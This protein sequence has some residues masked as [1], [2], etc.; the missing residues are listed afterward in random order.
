MNSQDTARAID[1]SRTPGAGRALRV[2]LVGGARLPRAALR[3]LIDRSPGFEV[4]GDGESPAEVLAN[5][6][7]PTP[8]VVL[9]D[10][11]DRPDAAADAIRRIQ[12][13]SATARILIVASRCDSAMGQRIVLAG[14]AGVVLKDNSPDHLLQAIRKVH[15][16]ELWIDRATT[17][18]LISGL[19]SSRRQAAADPEQRKIESLTPREHEVI[20]L[21][22]AGLN[23]K[24]IAGKMK[25]SENTVRH[26]LTAIFDKLGA[27]DRLELLVY[28]YRHKI[29]QPQS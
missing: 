17:A 5:G 6:S 3:M 11:D 29:V 9:F 22:A 10:V 13:A 14:A 28:A 12:Q 24:A 2:L 7:E 8:D 15:E 1:T 4:V 27:T 16:G 26:H 21:I 19:A 18:S 25:I 23:N 20:T